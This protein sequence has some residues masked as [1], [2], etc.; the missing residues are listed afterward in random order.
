MKSAKL[1]DGYSVVDQYILAVGRFGTFDIL[2][3][4]FVLGKGKGSS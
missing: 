3:W 2:F 4:G 1:S